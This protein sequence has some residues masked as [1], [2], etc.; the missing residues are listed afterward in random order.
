[1]TVRLWS[2]KTHQQ[3]GQALQH[4]AF[5]WCVSISPNEEMLVSGGGEGEVL[6]WSIENTLSAAI[7]LYSLCDS[8][9]VHRSNVKLGRHLYLEVLQDAETVIELNPSSHRGYELKHAALHGAQR[10][11]EAIEA[12][13]LMLSKLDDVSDQKIR[14]LRQRYVSPSEVD[15]AILRVIHAQLENAPLRLLNTSTGRLCDRETQINAFME[16]IEYKKLMSSSMT[17]GHLQMKPIKDAVMMYFR[18]VMLSHRWERKEPRLYDIQDK[19][20]YNFDPA[21]TVEKLQKFC[22][23]ARDAGYSWAWSDTC[24]IDQSN[25][26]EVQR[27]VN[28]MFVWY[29]QSALTIVY[30]SDVPPSSQ[31]GA[32]ANSVWNT[33]GWTVQEF[34]APRVILFYQA[35]WTLYLN[36]CSPNHKESIVIM[37]ELEDSTGIDARSL[38]TFRPGM[39]GAREKTQMG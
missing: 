28:S 13:K 25:N 9:F 5:A 24:C 11:G 10:Y 22:E 14:Q 19:V 39:T 32:L 2:T 15:D 36:D 38:V 17:H 18:W 6:F 16:S 7:Q 33:R 34:L 23:V 8:Y 3:I 30:L 1:M 26:A 37:R 21:G 12:F 35:D 29:R 27:S 4:T 20:V 31:P